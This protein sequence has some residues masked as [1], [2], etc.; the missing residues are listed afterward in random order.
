MGDR[1][2]LER[3]LAHPALRR[4]AVVAAVG[5]REL[6]PAGLELCARVGAALARAGHTVRTGGS[7]GA[8]Q[9]YAAGAT[10]GG[11][12]VELVVPWSGFEPAA[13][14]PGAAVVALD[15][16]LHAD[17]VALARDADPGRGAPRDHDDQ[18]LLAR[19][20]GI[21]L[22]G[23]GLGPAA[24]I[25]VA[26]HRGERPRGRTVHAIACAGRAGIPVVLLPEAG[27]GR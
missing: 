16:A 19:N 12:A 17:W 3:L 8:D 18:R 10:A 22:G 15:P 1:P 20:G 27:A 24:A 23:H 5:E 13:R 7:P 2:A 26:A 25:C 11:G 6:S 9:A 14:P 21:V 4:P